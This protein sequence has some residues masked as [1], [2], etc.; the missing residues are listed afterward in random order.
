MKDWQLNRQDYKE[1]WQKVGVEYELAA[2]LSEAIS[3]N[4]CIADAQAKKLWGFL[5]GECLD[6]E[7]DGYGSTVYHCDDCWE[8]LDKELGG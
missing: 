5:Q 3:I 2:E 8:Q 7:H 1:A 6:R 4:K